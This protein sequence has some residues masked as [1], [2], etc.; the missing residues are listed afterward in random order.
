LIQRTRSNK[1]LYDFVDIREEKDGRFPTTTQL[2]Q[3]FQIIE[4]LLTWDATFG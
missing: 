2:T 4:T 3:L 1:L